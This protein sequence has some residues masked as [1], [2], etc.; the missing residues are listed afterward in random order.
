MVCFICRDLEQAFKARLSEYIAARS[1]AYFR[2]SRKLAALKNVDMERAKNDLEE[3]QLVCV[4]A[5]NKST[6][7]PLRNVSALLPLWDV[8]ALLPLRG[9]STSLRQVAA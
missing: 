7:L 1:S 5:V 8:S 2:V 9:V 6:L 3:H 4:S